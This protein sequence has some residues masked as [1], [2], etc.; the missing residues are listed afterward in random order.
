MHFG[1]LSRLRKGWVIS[2][3]NLHSDSL[4]LLILQKT[5]KVNEYFDTPHLF[6]NLTICRH[7]EVYP[8]CN[9]CG[10]KVG[11]FSMNGKGH[12]INLLQL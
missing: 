4:S 1:A 12:Q 7:D 9:F 3:Q 5:K 10:N 6:Q 2:L 8:Y 11:M